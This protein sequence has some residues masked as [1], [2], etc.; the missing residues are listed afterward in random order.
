MIDDRRLTIYSAIDDLPN[1]PFE[2]RN[3]NEASIN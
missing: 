3:R 1:A 2:L